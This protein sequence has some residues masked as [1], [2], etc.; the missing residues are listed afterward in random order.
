MQNDWFGFIV[1]LGYG[2]VFGS[3]A[4]VVIWRFPRGESLSHPGSRC[5][6][7]GTSIRWYDNIPVVSWLRLGGRCR[8][9]EAPISPRY[10]AVEII[11]GLLW[12]LAWLTWG[13]TVRAAFGVAFF[14]LLLIL[15]AID[16]DTYRLPNA[17]V[18]LMAVIGTIGVVASAL[19][20]LEALPLMTAEGP[21]ASPVAFAVAGS[22]AGAG[23]ALGIALVYQLARKREG[24]GMGDVKLL[25][26][27]GPFL[28]LYTLLALFVASLVGA[29]VGV[30]VSR[31]SE[32]GLSA[33]IPFGPFLAL[34]AVVTAVV[35]P[36]IWGWY[37]GLLP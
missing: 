28:G 10:P 35:G 31:R 29:I 4:N 1:F 25:A 15:A 22:V 33:R 24:F 21:L 20:G 26:A 19:T 13:F 9:C 27:M 14:Y 12:V 32:D 7:C 2:L 6:S 37:A 8:A 16:L 18:G 17:L 34:G 36:A 11:S 3:F 23:L 30:A 5:P